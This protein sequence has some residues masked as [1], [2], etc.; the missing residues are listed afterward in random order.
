MGLVFY[1]YMFVICNHYIHFGEWS[2]SFPFLPFS[3]FPSS[4]P[5]ILPLPTIHTLF[6][7]L[8]IFRVSQNMLQ[9]LFLSSFTSIHSKQQYIG[10]HFS[11]F[12]ISLCFLMCTCVCVCM[13]GLD[14]S[15]SDW[16]KT[17]SESCFDSHFPNS[18]KCWTVFHILSSHWNFIFWEKSPV[19]I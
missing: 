18:Q 17:E 15:H 5:K 12:L 6:Y 3:W 1:W 7:T 16:S 4:S 14:D 13:C 9:S 8:F 11:H 19:L 10:L 2:V